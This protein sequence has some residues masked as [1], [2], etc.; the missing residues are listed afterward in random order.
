MPKKYACI[1]SFNETYYNEMAKSMVETYNHFW[2]KDIK[3][4]IYTEN[5]KLPQEATGE[6]IVE[7]DIHE[8]C[9]PQLKDILEWR[10]DHFTRGMLFKTYA[11]IHATKNID[12]DVIIYLD[13]DSITYRNITHSFLDSLLPNNELTAYMGV[14]MSKGKWKGNETEN[15]E[16]CIYLFNNKHPGAQK[17]MEHYENIYESRAIDDRER[18][19]KPHDTWAFTECVQLA[20]A[21]GHLVN[22]LHS[23]RTA[24]S[25]LKETVLGKYFRH[26]KAARKN[27]PDKEKYIKKIIKG[28]EAKDLDRLEKKNKKHGNLKNPNLKWTKLKDENSTNR[29]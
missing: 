8:K 21:Q 6:N 20:L 27:D 11:F 23:Q 13:A 22:D 17:F 28:A 1:T 24:H 9:D 7:W 15:A 2:P 29:S 26:F 5:F 16:T 4:Y 3:L 10:G 14:T 25:P 18:F 19:K 12:A